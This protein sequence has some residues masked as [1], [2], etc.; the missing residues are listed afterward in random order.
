MKTGRTSAVALAAALLAVPAAAQIA[1]LPPTSPFTGS[2]PAAPLAAGAVALGLDEAVERGLAHNLAVLNADERVARSEADRWRSLRELLPQVDAR[3]S[4]SRQTTNLAAFGFDTTLFPGVPSIVGP[5]NVF[6]ARLAASQTVFDLSAINDLR[7]DRHASEAARLDTLDTR[8]VVVLVVTDLYLQAAAGAQRIESAREQVATAEALHG[9]AT[10][11][12]D[13]GATTGIDVVRAQVQLQ[14]GRQRLIAAEHAFAKAQLRLARAIGLRTG[15]ALTLTD[16]A[17]TLPPAALSLDQALQ[18]AAVRRADY[19]A[20]VERLRAAEAAR[21]A[22]RAEALPTVGVR[23]DVGAL[24]SGPGDARRTYTLAGAVRVP[25]FDVGRRARTVESTAEVRERQAAV[26]DLAE[27]IDADVRSAYLDAQA[28]EQELA[29]AKERTALTRQELALARV[30]FTAG[31]TG[32]TEVIQAQ[33]AVALATDNEIASS[34]ALNAA[35]AALA[36]MLGAT[37]AAPDSRSRQARPAGTGAGAPGCRSP[38]TAPAA[39]SSSARAR[40]ASTC[41]TMFRSPTWAMNDVWCSSAAGCR[42]AP[43]RM[44]RRPEACSRSLSRASAWRPLASMA[45]ML[46]RRRITIGANPVRSAVASAS[47]SVSPNRNG[48]WMR[49]MVT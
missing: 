39:H 21:H 45:V 47:F 17:V 10:T 41:G 28:A 48:P 29:V 36:R 4:L 19:R 37:A 3:T 24:G 5:F 16:A 35:R 26:A 44:S 27:R 32:N 33:N 49:R 20:A 31:V 46:R 30:R 43:H 13:A 23:A 38:P 40:A 22:A 8:E 9:L 12:R 42:R 11:L 18:V 34:Y 1:A 25:L 2:V 14:T 6:D 15:Q 7:H